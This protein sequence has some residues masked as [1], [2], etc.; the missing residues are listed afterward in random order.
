MADYQVYSDDDSSVEAPPPPPAEDYSSDGSGDGPISAQKQSRDP[1]EEQLKIF[2][3]MSQYKDE[4]SADDIEDDGSVE[5][6]APRELL[7]RNVEKTP[8]KNNKR[9][10]LYAGIVA[11]LLLV[12]IIT[13]AVGFGTGAFQND[14]NSDRSAPTT[15]DGE[16][17]R[18]D[19]EI[20]DEETEEA[21]KMRE[22]IE[23]IV[24]SP[25]KLTDSTNPEF[26]ALAWMQ[27]QDPLQLDPDVFENHV[28]INQ[29]FALMSLWYQSDF[30]WADQTNWLTEDECTWF[31]V[32]CQNLEGR[33]N[34]Q[35]ESGQ[36]VVTQLILESNNLQG[37]IPEDIGLLE[38]LLVLNLSKNQ[39]TGT[40]PPSITDLRFLEELYLDNNSL[41]GNLEDLDMSRM[42]V[43]NTI[44]IAHNAFT[45]SLPP[46]FFTRTS[47]TRLVVDHNRFTG[48]I[49]NTIGNLQN[50]GKSFQRQCYTLW[51]LFLHR[52]LTHSNSLLVIFQSASPPL[53]TFLMDS[54]LLSL[55][56]C[57]TCS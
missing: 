21:R 50:L 51:N 3:G 45:G 47:L 36:A 34:L 40:I 39:H 4:P 54:Y 46:T 8:E 52:P 32:T 33:R 28:R 42:Q 49:P 2:E 6:E 55:D 35:E 1:Y 13:L 44:D 31:G 37:E 15:D 17:A 20:P 22:Y 14:G 53:Q 27:Y 29:R 19:V 9:V 38:Y 25:E 12:I 24:V 43:I 16:D 30:E 10:W 18:P 48:P 23:S 57:R 56:Y 7:D 41:D 11:C 5:S 26:Q